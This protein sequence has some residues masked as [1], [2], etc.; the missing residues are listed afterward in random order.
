[1]RPSKKLLNIHRST[2]LRLL[3]LRAIIRNADSDSWADL[4][5]RYSYVT[6]EALNLWCNFSRAYFLSF[7]L[8]PYREG[9]E[10]ISIGRPGIS[11]YQDA[12]DLIMLK[13]RPKVFQRGNWTRRDE[14]PWHVP[15]T[16]MD[17]CGEL[18]CSNIDDIVNAFSIRS[19]VFKH[20]PLFR[21]FYAHRHNLT[22]RAA[23]DVARSYSIPAFNH[24]TKV[25][26]EAAYS[27]PQPLIFDWLDD[28]SSV[29]ELLCQ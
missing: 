13:L 10:V 1:M 21:N 8:S 14:P 28:I 20:L 29:A 23:I 19:S 26:Q 2:E 6:I 7:V 9:G 12:L 15:K 17:C 5:Q 16:L 27:R 4:D 22:A 24:P 18:Q 3:K 11:S 25:L